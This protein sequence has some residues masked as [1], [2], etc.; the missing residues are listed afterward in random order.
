MFVNVYLC[1]GG[2]K[3][4]KRITVKEVFVVVLVCKW[5]MKMEFNVA[6]RS[7]ITY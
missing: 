3:T 4:Q 5:D 2:E 1:V 7:Y 6:I